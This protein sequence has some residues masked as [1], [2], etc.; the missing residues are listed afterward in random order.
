[1][2]SILAVN[3][4]FQPGKTDKPIKEANLPGNNPIATL[5]NNGI[6]TPKIPDVFLMDGF[7]SVSTVVDRRIF[8][9]PII[10]RQFIIVTDGITNRVHKK[11]GIIPEYITNKPKNPAVTG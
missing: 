10:I 6:P 11:F 4:L 8:N 3:K 2:I 5:I 9:P 1:V 7:D